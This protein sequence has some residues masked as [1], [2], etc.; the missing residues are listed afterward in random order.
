VQQ[1]LLLAAEMPSA[2]L[3]RL[4]ASPVRQGAGQY[5]DSCC[6]FRCLLLLL[7]ALLLLLLLLL[8][9]LML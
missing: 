8:L 2:V 7:L 6:T 9:V 5:I 4:A 3:L 1:G